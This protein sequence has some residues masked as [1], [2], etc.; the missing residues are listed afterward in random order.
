[1]RKHPLNLSLSNG[2]RESKTHLP[3]SNEGAYCAFAVSAIPPVI[4]LAVPAIPPTDAGLMSFAL[5]PIG[6]VAKA[7]RRAKMAAEV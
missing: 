5:A 2:Y 3:D 1:M 7:N 6:F 4:G